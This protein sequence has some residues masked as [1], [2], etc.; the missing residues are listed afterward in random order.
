[1]Q[2]L[3]PGVFK[4]SDGEVVTVDVKSTGA[5]TLFG[6][7]HSI[8]GAGTPLT[9]GQ[10]LK[11]TMDKSKATGT[12]FVPNA[13]SANLTLLFSFTSSSGGRYDLTTSG[14]DGGPAFPDQANQTGNTPEAIPYIF[15]I[16]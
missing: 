11:I 15:H 9:A 5:A 13:K 6:V 1:M 2:I 7:N 16:V 10:P 14:S 8:F 12:S 3:S 4:V